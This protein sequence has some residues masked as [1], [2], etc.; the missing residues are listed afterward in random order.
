MLTPRMPASSWQRTFEFIGSPAGFQSVN[1]LPNAPALARLRNSASGSFV[2]SG[3]VTDRLGLHLA[4]NL[5]ASTRVEREFIDRAAEQRR[6]AF[7]TLRLS[8]ERS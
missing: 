7:R 8:G 2:L 1:P 5:A 3:P 4:G 6:H